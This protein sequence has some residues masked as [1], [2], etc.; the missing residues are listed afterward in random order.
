[1]IGCLMDGLTYGRLTHV[2][3]ALTI[4]LLGGNISRVGYYLKTSIIRKES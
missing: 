3:D 2:G 4:R 1:M